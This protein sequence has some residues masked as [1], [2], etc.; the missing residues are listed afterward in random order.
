MNFRDG[1]NSAVRRPLAGREATLHQH[2][3]GSIP[4]IPSSSASLP[5]GK[6]TFEANKRLAIS[7]AHVTSY[8][9]VQSNDSST[10]L[11]G[12]A[13]VIVKKTTERDDVSDAIASFTY[14][15]LNM[16]LRSFSSSVGS[17]LTVRDF[18]ADYTI[19]GVNRAEATIRKSTN[20]QNATVLKRVG[21]FQ[22][23]LLKDG[24]IYIP[25]IWGDPSALQRIGFLLQRRGIIDLKTPQNDHKVRALQL[26]PAW[27]HSGSRS[28][29]FQNYGLQLLSSSLIV[30]IVD[31]PADRISFKRTREDEEKI[32]E[33]YRNFL[34]KRISS[35]NEDAASRLFSTSSSS[36]SSSSSFSSSSLISTTTV[37]YSSTVSKLSYDTT[38]ADLKRFVN[39]IFKD[40]SLGL[41][42]S[43]LRL[44]RKQRNVKQVTG[45]YWSV[46]YSE[47]SEIANP[48]IELEVTKHRGNFLEWRKF[49]DNWDVIREEAPFLSVGVVCTTAPGRSFQQHEIDA[50]TNAPNHDAGFK[51]YQE[52][53]E[54]GQIGICIRTS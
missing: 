54:M 38:K 21:Y 15:D 53:N 13:P 31:T 49:G 41:D 50:L 14:P 27:S 44:V 28:Y 5:T 26:V 29:I 19:S 23:S 6:A 52:F 34:S 39:Q 47:K 43:V 46:C 16:Y 4:F 1:F 33:E 40:Q 9:D 32:K 20:Y 2:G 42:Q 48:D 17:I 22:I 10:E 8:I 25:N 18:M 36:S 12:G 45:T 35:R 24:F 3:T 30:D 37:R 11:L 51:Q 7:N